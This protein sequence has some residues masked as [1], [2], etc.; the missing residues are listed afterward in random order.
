[1]PNPRTIK[2][3][4]N[5]Y[6]YCMKERPFLCMGDIQGLNEGNGKDSCE[7]RQLYRHKPIVQDGY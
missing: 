2:G 6:S 5:H 7:F 4:S 3:F 1:M